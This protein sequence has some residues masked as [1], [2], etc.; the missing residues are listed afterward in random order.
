[1]SVSMAQEPP[2]HVRFFGGCLSAVILGWIIW[3]IIYFCFRGFG[4]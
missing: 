3:A 4:S 2:E 1:M